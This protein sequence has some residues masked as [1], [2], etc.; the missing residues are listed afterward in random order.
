MAIIDKFCGK[1][2][3]LLQIPYFK[4][5]IAKK[6]FLF[7]TCD[8]IAYNMKRCLRFSIF[9]YWVS[10]NLANCTYGWS[11]LKQYHTIVKKNTNFDKPSFNLKVAKN[12]HNSPQYEK[13][14]KNLYFH[15]LSI[16]KFD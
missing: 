3:I 14:L 12:H 4:K 2:N 9:I 5:K 6:E 1:G 11:S 16:A 10:P 8:T 13:V 7:K 15:I